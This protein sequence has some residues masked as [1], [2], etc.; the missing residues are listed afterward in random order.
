M[1]NTPKVDM[2]TSFSGGEFTPALAG[3]V[4]FDAY[5]SG[6]RFIENLIPEVQ[7]GLK[8]F[9]GTREIAVLS[10][11]NDYVM[12]PFDGLDVPAVLVF[13]D[14]VISVVDSDDYYDTG[15]GFSFSGL[16]KLDWAQQNSVVYFAH[17]SSAPFFVRYLGRGDDNKLVFTIGEMGFVDVPYFPVG[18]NG[19]YGGTVIT[20]GES[21]LVNVS[22]QAVV[23]LRLPLPSFLSG[24]VGEKNVLRDSSLTTE[25]ALMYSVGNQHPTVSFGNTTVVVSRRRNG[26]V[27]DIYS[28]LTGN[29]H[30]GLGWLVSGGGLYPTLFQAR[31][32]Y[33]TISKVDLLNAIKT[34]FSGAVLEGDF[35]YLNAGITGH[36][37]GDEYCISVRQGASSS[38]YPNS[39]TLYASDTEYPNP[40][41][42]YSY[43][44][45]FAAWAEDGDYVEAS[46]SSDGFTEVGM[47]GRKIKFQLEANTNVLS[48]A[49]GVS[50][51][52][53]D[54]RYSSGSYY[55]ATTSGTTGSVQP[56]HHSGI[57][58]DGSVFWRYLH[59]G[60]GTATVVSVQDETHLTAV[61]D[62]VLP[63]LSLGGNSY[64]WRNY[65]WSMWGYR[66][67][68]PN[69]VFFF[70]GRLC[71]FC[72]TA[73]YGCWFQASKTD[74]FLDFS[75]EEYGQ[76]LDNCAINTLVSGYPDNNINWHMS[77]D[78][79]YCGSYSGEYNIMGSDGSGMLSP[80]S[81]FVDPITTIG[82]APVQ[83]LRY[84]GLNLFVG[85]TRDEIYS[86]SYDYTTDDYVPENI[87]FMSSHLLSQGVRR[88]VALDNVDRNIYFNSMDNN[89]CV[90]NYVKEVKYLGYY[91]INLDGE[92]MDVVSSNAGEKSAMY[93]IVKRGDVYTIERADSDAPSYML[94]RKHFDL[95]LLGETIDLTE[96]VGKEVWIKNSDDGQF[97]KTTIGSYDAIPRLPASWQHID[98]GLPMPCVLHGQAM[99]GEKLEGL[100][101][102][103]VRFIVRLRDAGAFSYGSSVD[104]DK[105]YDYNK[106][107]VM[108]GESWDASHKLITGDIQLPASFG[109][110][111]GQ[112]QGKGEYPN[113]TGIGLNMYMNTPEPFCLLSVSCI[114]V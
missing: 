89:L 42:G 19:N 53:G 5:K 8:K 107:N 30:T 108:A 14:N 78:R 16:N 18:W 57:F 45:S 21:G 17:P 111:V 31:V 99:S 68:Y 48:W 96:F 104:F 88:W 58:G 40:P 9:Y 39:G 32:K 37:E 46:V 90:I 41:T 83:A 3:H 112:N 15:L 59:S 62:G 84:R 70:K 64:H 94:C 38:T 87:G 86:I 26:V 27:T 1:A 4:D 43:Q 6:S 114:Y 81:C 109:Y 80:T 65:Q 98:V 97:Y 44:P 71:Y 77:G 102:K 10:E 23:S 60:Y 73:G 75:T 2:I 91:R 35:V 79:L 92:T 49:E 52:S 13:H 28:I 61:V 72:S 51:S 55:E 100:Q 66:G 34:V 36:E 22:A 110:T 25:P 95:D 47:V 69:Q 74:D 93:A 11:P 24:T 103:S 50:V 105:R 67:V 63:V 54:I 76:V 101:Q 113:D 7:G 33:K 106:W 85:R 29:E 20:D 82:G 56:I 12:V